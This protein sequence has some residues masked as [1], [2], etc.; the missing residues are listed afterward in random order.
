MAAP[1]PRIPPE[2]E[3][4]R[5]PEQ[6]TPA[7]V[8]PFPPQATAPDEPIPLHDSAASA[9]LGAEGLSRLRARHAEI[10]ARI[11]EKVAVQVRRE[12]L[13]ADA[14]RLNPDSWVTD[15]EVTAGLEAYETVFETLRAVIGRRRKRRRR[16]GAGERAEVAAPGE[17]LGATPEGAAAHD[18]EDPAGEDEPADP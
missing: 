8:I 14:E 1:Q 4:A 6:P 2:P 12:Q 17:Q 3:T 10:L 15:A 11:A 13:K 18:D 16:R 9:R 7:V 5:A